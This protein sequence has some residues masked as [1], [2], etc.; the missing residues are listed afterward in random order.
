MSKP[1]TRVAF[2]AL[3]VLVLVVGIY[4]TV[5]AATS[6]AS[7]SGERVVTTAGLLPDTSHVRSAGQSLSTYYYDEGVYSDNS[8]GHGGCERDN[9]DSPDD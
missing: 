7:L 2:L 6:R 8:E 9:Y 4:F 3:I 1:V 5:Q